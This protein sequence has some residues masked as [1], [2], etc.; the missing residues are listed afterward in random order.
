MA[1][2]DKLIKKEAPN[3][4]ELPLESVIQNVESIEDL[5]K[6]E[7]KI[8]TEIENVDVPVDNDTKTEP[9]TKTDE[10]EKEDGTTQDAASSNK[11]DDPDPGA[12][13]KDIK[14]D[15]TDNVRTTFNIPKKFK[16]IE[17]YAKW[18]HE[19]EQ[20]KTR[21][22]QERA[23]LVKKQQETEKELAYLKGKSDVPVPKSVHQEEQEASER[24]ELNNKF[25]DEYDRDPIGAMARLFDAQETKRQEKY[26]VEQTKI[27]QQEKSTAMVSRFETETKALKSV[28][29][30]EEYRNI[31]PELGR[32]AVENEKAGTPLQSVNHVYAVY[33][34]EQ[35]L[36]YKKNEQEQE[37]KKT[38]KKKVFSENSNVNRKDDENV[39]KKIDKA[40]SIEELDAAMEKFVV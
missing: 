35:S 17:D 31:E 18:G 8:D 21:V 39:N 3:Q 36:K 32:I 37:V 12:E 5:E 10:G 27:K 9:E 19:A 38:M 6:L 25:R 4:D 29:G 2:D 24:E 1:V 23:D 15:I 22:E 26:Q 7:T 40:E 14:T 30:E 11:E 20:Q 13:P 16:Y 28:I 33:R 34:S